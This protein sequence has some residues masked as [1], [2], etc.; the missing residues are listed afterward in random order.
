MPMAIMAVI[1]CVWG[2]RRL[3]THSGQTERRVRIFSQHTEASLLLSYL[4]RAINTNANVSNRAS[5][6]HHRDER[7]QHGLTRT[8][9]RLHQVLPTVVSVQFK[10]LRCSELEGLGV[11]YLRADSSIDCDSPE[12]DDFVGNIV[13]LLALYLCIPL[14]YLGLL[15]RVSDRLHVPIP[16]SVATGNGNSRRRVS[17]AENILF[18]QAALRMQEQ[19]DPQLRPLKFLYKGY[20]P[21]YWYAN[22]NSKYY[23]T[24]I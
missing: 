8:H 23:F 21:Q 12:Y 7:A 1:W 22:S 11:R 13:W 14:V 9:A 3:C 15:S 16:V 18:E 10:S 6:K 24:K 5:K 17:F 2:L 4:V 19:N 20:H